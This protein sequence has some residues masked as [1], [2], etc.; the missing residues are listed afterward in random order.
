MRA[1]EALTEINL[2]DLVSSFGWQDQPVPA[3]LLR[4]VFR[5][6]AQK[7]A[8][9]MLAFDAITGPESLPEGARQT[10]R[11]FAR[12][13]ECFGL[14]HVPS[15]GPVVFLSNHPGMIDTLALFAAINRPDLRVIALDRPFLLSL[16]SVARHLLFVSDDPQTRIRAVRQAGSHLREGGALLSFPAGQIEPDPQVYPGALESLENWTDS[17]GVFIRFAPGTVIVPVL[18]SGVLWEPA[19]KFPLV[20]IKK[21]RLDREKLGAS[22]QLLAHILFNAHPLR[23]TLQFARPIT[24]DEIGSRDLAAAHCKIMERMRALVQNPPRAGGIVMKPSLA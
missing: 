14:E 1:F 8:R 21:N 19:V 15:S 10:L 16:P 13:L 4:R 2:D 23:V 6:P 24:L 12:E 22:L 11:G 3:W 18:V 7:F 5:A 17:A 20:L 9:M